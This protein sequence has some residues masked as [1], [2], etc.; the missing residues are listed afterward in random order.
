[1][2][3]IIID[4][5][6]LALEVLYRQLM[7]IKDVEVVNRYTSIK[8]AV[9]ALPMDNPDAVFLDIEM[10]KD[11]GLHASQL[12]QTPNKK[13]PIVFVTAYAQYAVEA[14]EIN[15]LDYLLKPVTKERLLESIKR[16]KSQIAEERTSAT[17]IVYCLGQFRVVDMKGNEV[18]WRTKKVKEL[19]AYLWHH[20]S[21]PISRTAILND[22]WPDNHQSKSNTILN[23]TLYQLRKSLKNYGVE[24]PIQYQND[25]YS[26]NFNVASDLDDL[27]VMM[28]K[29]QC[30]ERLLTGN[31]SY[32]GNEPYSWSSLYNGFL[33][34]KIVHFMIDYI[35]LQTEQQNLSPENDALVNHLMLLDPYNVKCG[36]AILR[37]HALSNSKKRVLDVYTIIKQ[38]YHE[39]LGEE[40][41]SE[42]EEVYKK[43]VNHIT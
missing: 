39:E 28:Q 2:K 26:L 36:I 4:D 35:T 18:K 29:G 12:F 8:D 27:E 43:I 6:K 23:T 17:F 42:L 25:A 11:F 33:L 19:F 32:M 24:E 37:Y 20:R 3:V 31:T 9:D 30:H 22:L 38:Q 40:I 34:A 13:R 10:G 14:F 41:D 21:A 15:A 1:M 7:E 5:E 16:I